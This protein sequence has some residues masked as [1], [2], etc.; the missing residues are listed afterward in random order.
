MIC[1]SISSVLKLICCVQ[2]VYIL[3]VS[4][5]HSPFDP[6]IPLSLGKKLLQKEREPQPSHR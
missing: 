6:F 2:D 3:K 5:N 4:E 1:R